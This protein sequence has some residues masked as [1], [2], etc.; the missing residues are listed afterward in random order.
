MSHFLHRR[1]FIGLSAGFA[2]SLYANQPRRTFPTEPRARLAVSTYPFRSLISSPKADGDQP[3]GAKMTLEQFA[4]TIAPKL[5][6]PGI[7]P[8][9][10]HFR[11]TD[12]EYVRGLRAAFDAAGVRVVN[13][14]VDVSAHLCGTAEERQAALDVYK[15]WVDTAIILG[16]PGIRVHLPHGDKPG[17]ISCAV[18]SLKELAAYGASNS[19]AINLENDEPQTE[20][21]ERIVQVILAVNSPYL[22]ALPDF[23][24]SML[25][26]NDSAYNNAALEKMFPLAFNISHVKDM[27]HDGNTTYRVN[28]DEIFAIAKKAGYR[29]YFSMEWE[30]VGEPYEGT[31]KLIEAS[32]R[33]LS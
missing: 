33:N 7:E 6:V 32:L 22:R 21:P 24:N 19:T 9:S 20:Q 5:K 1:A 27:E 10:H 17:E 23:C 2:T 15:K 28:M 11:S 18:S 26:Q 30:G 13:I 14:P 29:G 25:I 16:S 8:W 31:Q 4:A 3:A 12:P